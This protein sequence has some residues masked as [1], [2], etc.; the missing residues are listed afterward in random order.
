MPRRKFLKL[1]GGGV[2]LAAA[3][4]VTGLVVSG[5]P[6]T[7]AREPWQ[8]A[9][10]Y[11][12]PMRRALSYALLAPNPHNMQPWIIDLV[13]ET[14]AVL[15][16]DL[17]RRLPATDPYDR[18]ITIG[19]GAF[20]EL[21]SIAA[22]SDGFTADITPFPEG[23]D[24]RTLDKRP[25]ARI[26]LNTNQA[27]ADPL[28]DQIPHRRSAKTVYDETPLT[29]PD[30]SKLT[31]AGCSFGQTCLN[32]NTQET[33]RTLKDL[34]WRAHEMEV[35]TPAAMKE[36]VDV[37]RIGRG[38]VARNPDG[39]ELERVG[40]Q[41]G[42][43]LGIVSRETLGDPYSTAFKQGLEM[44]RD[45][46]FSSTGF[47]WISNANA[48]RTDQIYAGR[49]YARINLKATELGIGMHP[50]SQALQEY[51]E[52]S[53]LY[54]EVHALLGDGQRIQMLYRLGY[55][56]RPG[57]TPRWPLETLIERSRTI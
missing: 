35:I 12:D 56:K 36:S 14:E 30:L 7:K 10:Q 6:S 4:G 47:G 54:Q 18:Q 27:S 52:M 55:T 32:T 48:N 23:D 39:I 41:A 13:S 2:V 29:E 34:T 8:L 22:S 42:R 50:W 37:M 49:A 28:F 20:L 46:A 1:V 51:E 9:G 38:E 44:Y 16:V 3:A 43:A 5:Q 31:E 11:P 53:E 26:V 45:L 33:I 57:R 15:F 19:C 40:I 21:L 25:I 17:E 24:L